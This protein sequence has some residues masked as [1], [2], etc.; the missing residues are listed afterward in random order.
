MAKQ[1]GV[2]KS[3]LLMPVFSLPNKY[4]IGDFGSAA[5]QFLSILT[6]CGFHSWQLLPLTPVGSGYSPYQSESAYAGNFMYISPEILVEAGLVTPAECLAAGYAGDSTHVDYAWVRDR[7][8]DLLQQAYSRI[9]ASYRSEMAAYA[10]RE[11]DWLDDYA[12][13]A[14]IRQQ[15]NGK[16]WWGWDEKNLS[17]ADPEAV[18]DFCRQHKQD[19][20]YIRFLAYEFSRQWH[21][22]KEKANKHGIELIGDIPIYVAA[23]SADVWANRRFFKISEDQRL[24]HVAGVPPD[25]FS[26]DGQK[27]GNPLYDW[28]ALKEDNYTWWIRRIQAGLKNFDCVRIDHFRGFERYFAI[29]SEA[30]TAKEG[31]WV[32]G[33]GHDLFNA[34]F[35]AL[36]DASIIA[37]DLGD[38]DDAVRRFLEQTGLPGMNVLQFSFDL[39]GSERDRPHRYLENSVAYS[40]TH[41]NTTLNGWLRDLDDQQRQLVTDYCGGADRKSLLRCLW[42]THAERVII[43]VQDCLGLGNDARINTPG[44]IGGNWCF[45]FTESQLDAID[46]DYFLR[47]NQL[48]GRFFIS[49]A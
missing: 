33:P 42:Q 30:E 22:L 17:L 15:Q 46:H 24:T 11:S 38:I 31:Q 6:A 23:D 37:E 3:G 35:R 29:P 19:V 18:A 34:I 9:D 5:D 13:F 45:R 8:T 43:P 44:T 40:G 14:V 1:T 28:H 10:E 2:R 4:G 20:D 39:Y 48:F 49:G 36:P 47:L 32:Q 7:R 12:A 27:W 16:P 21:L 25:Y 41:D 26:P